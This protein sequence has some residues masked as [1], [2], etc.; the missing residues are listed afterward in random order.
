M[1]FV[2]DNIRSAWNVGSAM[3]TADATGSEVIMVGYTSRPI[4]KTKALIQKTAIGAEETVTWSHFESPVEVFDTYPQA[5]F[6][7]IEI[8]NDSQSI[9]EFIKYTPKIT[10]RQIILWFGNEIHGVSEQVMNQC[11]HTLHLPMKGSK[12]SINVAT[13]IAAASYLISF[14]Q[15]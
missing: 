4:G 6:I 14:W 12:E 8:S 11:H 15:E 7:A 2:L 13:C 1:I 5:L 10:D 3:R 9:F